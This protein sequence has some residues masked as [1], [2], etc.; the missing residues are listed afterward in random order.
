M[1]DVEERKRDGPFHREPSWKRCGSW[2]GGSACE[3]YERSCASEVLVDFPFS[4]QIPGSMYESRTTGRTG[5]VF[6]QIFMRWG[7]FLH[8]FQRFSSA[9]VALLGGFPEPLLCF[10]GIL[11]RAGPFVA[12]FSQQELGLRPG[13]SAAVCRENPRRARAG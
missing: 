12:A 7:G 3:C 11:R 6:L 9:F 2:G 5:L 10:L 8:G 1:G 13:R 4:R